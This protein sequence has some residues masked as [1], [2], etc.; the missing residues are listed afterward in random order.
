M[1]IETQKSESPRWAI[2]GL[3]KNVADEAID[4]I[5]S[6]YLPTSHLSSLFFPQSTL[7]Y[8]PVH[9]QGIILSS[10]QAGKGGSLCLE[11]S[12]GVVA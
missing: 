2:P 3:S 4:S 12:Q 11:I 5:G 7:F 10:V 1:C 9:G 6:L 8:H